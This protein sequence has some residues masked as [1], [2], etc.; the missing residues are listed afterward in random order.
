MFAAST[1]ERIAEIK[2]AFRIVRP[3]EEMPYSSEVK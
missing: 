3:K 2:E 1:D